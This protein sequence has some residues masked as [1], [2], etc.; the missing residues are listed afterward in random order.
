MRHRVKDAPEIEMIP[1]NPSGS[2][3]K[4]SEKI[5]KLHLFVFVISS[6]EN[7]WIEI[8]YSLRT[9]DF[10][11]A[12]TNLRLSNSP[13]QRKNAQ[14]LFYEFWSVKPPFTGPFDPHGQIQHV[15][16]KLDDNS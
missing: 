11:N 1:M 12:F 7:D 8:N 3:L 15:V 4:K 9:S 5:L 10:E 2:I 16:E 6:N 14:L 13:P